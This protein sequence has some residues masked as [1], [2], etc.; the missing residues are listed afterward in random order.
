[1]T[2]GRAGADG[3]HSAAPGEERPAEEACGP[4]RGVVRTA[5]AVMRRDGGRLHGR[6]ARVAGL[7]TLGGLLLAVVGFVV[8]WPEF[9]AMRQGAIQA[10]IDE[11]SYAP[12]GSRVNTLWLILLACLPFLILLLHLGCAAIQTAAVRAHGRFRAVL[13]VYA[14]R[15]VC[16]W[17]PVVL[18]VLVEETFTTTLFREHTVIVPKWE[19]PDL[20][21][22]LRYGPPLLGVLTALV[23][24]LSWTLAPAVAATEGLAPVAALRRSWSLVWGG[25][26]AWFR[27]VAVALPL[28]GI[29]VAVC[30]LLHQAARPLRAGTVSL[31]L[32]RGPDNT[33]AAYVAGLLV[34]IAV[35][36]LLTGALTLPPAH[37][38]FAAL[39][40]RLVAD[41]E[42]RTAVTAASRS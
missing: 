6:A 40:Q 30:L 14:L 39:H 3:P 37:T 19:H 15:G 27:T 41:R 2:N 32:D 8:A 23:L 16:V 31:F 38:T 7:V 12:D 10:R 36:L 22:L 11:D 5:L 13:G 24:R 18:G 25:A 35:A 42:R 26:A 33:Y 28:G 29:T 9:T 17:V 1:M 34:P 20:F 4:R 21:V